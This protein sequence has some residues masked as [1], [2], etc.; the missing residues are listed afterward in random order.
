KSAPFEWVRRYRGVFLGTFLGVNA[1]ALAIA[2]TAQSQANIRD[3]M[4]DLRED[5][6]LSGLVSMGPEL[7]TFFLDRG[8]V[9]RARVSR[10]DLVWLGRVLADMKRSE[11]VLPNRFL[12]FEPDCGAMELM[13]ASLALR[14]ESPAV[15]PGFWADRI[16]FGLNAKHNRRRAP[17]YL[18]RCERP[19]LA[20]SH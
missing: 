14:C 11:N 18:Y 20:S 3:A 1:V 12:C 9:P 6:Q 2:T 8:D 13:L 16:A 5:G 7:Q 15:F 19:A 10:P 17:V 4:I